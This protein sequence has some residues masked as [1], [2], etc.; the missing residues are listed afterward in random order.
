MELK[1]SIYYLENDVY[2]NETYKEELKEQIKSCFEFDIK[3]WIN[4]LESGKENEFC[5]VNFSLIGQSFSKDEDIA[6]GSYTTKY[7]RTI[8]AIIPKV[9]KDLF[10]HYFQE[11]YDINN[12]EELDELVPNDLDIKDY[13][14]HIIT[15]IK[16]LEL[17]GY[18]IIIKD[19][20]K[21]FMKYSCNRHTALWTEE[22]AKTEIINIEKL[23]DKHK[24][25]I[26]PKRF[27][28]IICDIASKK[29]KEINK[30]LTL[31]GF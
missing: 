11:Y 13:N 7:L 8:E 9:I 25:N 29:Y 21:S 30:Q 28:K 14:N 24:V 23:N 19:E 3:D 16:D 26:L 31:E 27:I 10:S 5:V 2:N 4:Y 12:E 20:E 18:C 6:S 1:N 17:G 22:N 15:L